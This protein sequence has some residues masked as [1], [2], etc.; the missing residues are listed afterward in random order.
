MNTPMSSHNSSVMSVGDWLITL[1]I[2]TVIPIV[3][4]V[5]AFV[6]AFSSGTNENK[7]NFCRAILILWAI[8]LVL[9]IIIFAIFGAAIMSAGNTM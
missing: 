7:R 3:N 9:Y 5:M 2:L 6:W 4:I 1:V 8:I